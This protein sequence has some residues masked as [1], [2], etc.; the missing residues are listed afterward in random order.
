MP[1]SS[2]FQTERGGKDKK[3]DSGLCLPGGS[4]NRTT[5]RTLSKNTKVKSW[6]Y[7]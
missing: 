4:K 5:K 6:Q 1:P 3:R 7:R 2:D